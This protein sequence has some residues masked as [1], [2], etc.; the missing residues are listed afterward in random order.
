MAFDSQREKGWTEK[1]MAK[2]ELKSVKKV[3]HNAIRK[4]E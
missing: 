2:Q 3:D 4:F 1:L